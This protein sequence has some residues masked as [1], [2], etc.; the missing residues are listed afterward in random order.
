MTPF[1][2]TFIFLITTLAGINLH[3]SIKNE[4]ELCQLK[5]EYIAVIRHIKRILDEIKNDMDRDR[6]E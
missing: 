4:K 1:L 5:T 6:G 2:F 3:I